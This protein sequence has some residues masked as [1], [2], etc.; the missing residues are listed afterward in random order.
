VSTRLH[1]QTKDK[2]D[3]LRDPATRAYF[4]DSD[5]EAWPVGQDLLDK[6]LAQT[7]RTIAENGANAFYTGVIAKDIAD[8]VL[9]LVSDA[10]RFVNG[11]V[12]CVDGGGSIDA[13]KLAVE[14]PEGA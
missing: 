2:Q 8:A 4:L 13:F 6:V 3:R 7:L 12:L 5:G 11:Q 9:F 14:P 10:A 1:R